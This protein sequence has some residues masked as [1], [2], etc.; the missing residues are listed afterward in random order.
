MIGR[1][2]LNAVRSRDIAIAST[3]ERQRIDECFTEDD[4][5]CAVRST[6]S[7]IPHAAMWAGQI[8]MER[9]ALRQ[10]RRDLAAVDLRHFAGL[11]HDRHHE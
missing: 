4:L 2:A 1:E 8:Q 7:C 3:P 11:T 9:C 10:V 6:R 5:L